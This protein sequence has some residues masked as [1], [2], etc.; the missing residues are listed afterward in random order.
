MARPRTPIG[1]FGAFTFTNTADGRVRARARYRDEDGKL[2]RVEVVGVNRAAAERT[3]KSK[4]SDRASRASVGCGEITADTAF[5]DLAATWLEDVAS[6][7]SLS[8]R[9]RELYETNMRTLVLPALQHFALREL[10]VGRVDRFLKAQARI[11]HSRAQQSKNVLRQAL[12]LAVRYEAIPRNPVDGA[13]RLRKPPSKPTALAPEMVQAIRTAVRDWRRAAGTVGPKPDGQLEALIDVMVGTS[14]RIGEALAIRR[15]DVDVTSSPPTVRIAGTIVTPKRNPPHRQ[16]HPKTSRSDRIVALPSFT[17]A[18]LRQRSAALDDAD[19]ERLI[20]VS[21]KGTPLT[22]NNIRTRL[23]KILAEAEIDRVTPHAFRRAVATVLNSAGGAELAA[24]A[25]GHTSPEITRAHY[26]ETA[27]QVDP[28]TAEI[29][30]QF[31][32]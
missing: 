28:R 26:I 17:A 2:R 30:E 21:R 5:E 4:L 10:T 22:P 20:F 12:G 13:S 29:L 18:A 11:S 15:C 25:L 3:L 7:A 6:N 14:A 8:P 32:P 1:T 9:T 31:G 19:P 23:R 16:D 27:D 24:E